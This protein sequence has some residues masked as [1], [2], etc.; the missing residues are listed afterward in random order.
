MMCDYCDSE[1][2]RVS[3]YGDDETVVGGGQ[4]TIY[5]CDHCSS[6]CSHPGDPYATF[7]R[8][9]SLTVKTNQRG[10]DDDR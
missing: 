3:Y 10:H 8:E 7:D 9:E 6:P 1:A 5:H 4:A 2:T